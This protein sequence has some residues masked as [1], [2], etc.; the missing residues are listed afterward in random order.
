MESVWSFGTN[1]TWVDWSRLLRR[2]AR[3]ALDVG[4]ASDISVVRMRGLA[5]C[6]L[7]L[8]HSHVGRRISLIFLAKHHDAAPNAGADQQR[9]ASEQQC[10]APECASERDLVVFVDVATFEINHVIL[11]LYDVG[12]KS[13]YQQY[14]PV[15]LSA[16]LSTDIA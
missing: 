1:G 16:R 10:V 14:W 12:D 3:C 4:G 15:L 13:N 2:L 6:E 5:V 11:A 8:A 7:R 9:D